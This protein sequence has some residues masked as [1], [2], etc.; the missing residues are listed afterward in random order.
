MRA[1]AEL[2]RRRRDRLKGLAYTPRGAAVRL[3]EDA[4]AEVGL[5]GPAG[6]GKSRACLQKVHRLALDYPGMRA[7]IVR[8]TRASLSESTLVTFEQHVLGEDNPVGQGPTRQHRQV[9]RYPNGSV[10]V[11]GGMDRAT[12]I[13][14]TEFDVVYVPE[15]VELTITDYESLLTRLRNGVVPFQQIIFDCNPDAPT[16]WLKARADAGQARMYESRHE[17]NPRLWDEAA[18]VWTPEGAAYLAKLDGLTGVRKD[19]LRYGRWAIAEGAVYEFDRAVHLVDR[20]EIPA[21]WQR[22]RVVDF[23]FTN[24]FVCQWW[25]MDLDG[26]LYLYREMYMTRRTVRRHAVDIRQWSEGEEYVF[27]V[28]DHDAEDRET[29]AEEGIYTLPAIKDV[30]TGIQAVQE[31]LKVQGDG[32]PRLFVMRDSLVEVDEALREDTKPYCTEQEFDSYVWPKGQDGKAVKEQ[33]VKLFDHGMD[34][35]RY[36][37]MA[38]PENAGPMFLYSEV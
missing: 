24:P 18:H 5:S 12:R 21:D 20:F 31:R 22:F 27:T 1:R 2:E 19:R 10:I 3:Q 36:L 17:D 38:C 8:K 4:S 33:P 7:L 16:H 34:A 6:T 32:K 15:A 26:R 25:A 11:V 14:S 9:Y 35:M 29:L 30:T 28:A 37:V 23:G 13:M